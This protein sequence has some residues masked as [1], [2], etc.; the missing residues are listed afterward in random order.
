MTAI[1]MPPESP[2]AAFDFAS[3]PL[4]GTQL[5]LYATRLLHHGAGFMESIPLIAIAS[6]SVGYERHEQRIG[7][8][9]A[10]VVLAIAL[11]AMS[12]PLAGFAASAAAEVSGSQ[13][14]AELLR[15]ALRALEALAGGLLPVAGFACIAAGA[16]LIVFGWI[17]T[18]TLALMLPAAERAYP[19]RGQN[20]L[21]VDFAELLAER[22]AQRTH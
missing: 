8:G 1:T 10:L 9:A 13:A 6:V 12:G 17:G 4:R 3:G 20:R 14:I 19:V 5:S 2:I 11:F 15:G 7:W 16:A 18:T 22:V 21:L